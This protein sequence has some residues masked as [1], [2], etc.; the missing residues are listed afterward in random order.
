MLMKIPEK[1]IDFKI[2]TKFP[3]KQIQESFNYYL[4]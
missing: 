1:Q 3:K 2:R 4:L